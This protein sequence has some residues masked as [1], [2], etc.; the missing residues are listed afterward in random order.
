MSCSASLLGS[1]RIH[2][3]APRGVLRH[4][5][6]S[7]PGPLRFAGKALRPSRRHPETPSRRPLAVPHDYSRK[8]AAARMRGRC[9]EENRCESRSS[10]AHQSLRS[11]C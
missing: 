3:L 2:R 1:I 10:C 11:G 6:G 4:T 8:N 7:P 9:T 5:A